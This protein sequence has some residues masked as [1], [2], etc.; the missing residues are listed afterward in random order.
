MIRPRPTAR[1]LLLDPDDRILLMQ[2]RDVHDPLRAPFW[3]TVGGGVDDGESVL[4][5]ARREIVEE[6]G[7]Q[8]T[9]VGPL[10]WRAEATI[11]GF[12]GEP[13]LMQEHYVLARCEA[14]VLS[15]EGW[16]DVE[17]SFALDMRWW[18]LDEITRSAETIYPVDL[19]RRLAAFFAD[20]RRVPR[21]APPD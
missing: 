8:P 5:A 7:L 12:D 15:R 18:T 16:T 4:Q 17:R 6:T 14:G 9:K 1:V 2:A 11:R 20:D 13:M 10:L 19:A 21:S 3:F